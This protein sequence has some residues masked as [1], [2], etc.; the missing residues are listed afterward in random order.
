[1]DGN[2]IVAIQALDPRYTKPIVNEN[3][4][5]LGYLQNL[6]GIRTFTKDEVYHIRDGNDPDNEA[7][8]YSKMNSLFLDLETDKEARESNLAFFKN[9]QTPA[10]I[11]LLDPEYSNTDEDGNEDVAFRNKL[12]E[13][14]TS[15]ANTGGKNAH[16][17]MFL[18]GVKE[19][20]KIQDKINDMEFIE[21]R[22]FTRELVNSAYGMNADVQGVTENS[23]KSTGVTQST[24]YHKAIEQKNIFWGKVL[25]KVLAR[26]N[27][28]YNFVILQDD[29]TLLAIKSTIAG[30]LYEK[31]L[32]T[33]NEAR[34]I[35][36]YEEVDEGDTFRVEGSTNNTNMEDDKNTK[37]KK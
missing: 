2:T 36:Q 3:G 22:K 25:T 1:M 19:I 8:G 21:Q 13:I 23:N 6:N 11:V 30:D 14:F 34:D 15:G 20:V 33:R 29:L 35:I 31:G 27:P 5:V 9:N 7:I 37:K 24:E 32:L 26:I 12:K 18:E 4:T 16:R 28:S 10:S 17:S